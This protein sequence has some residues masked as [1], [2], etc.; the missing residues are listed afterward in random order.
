MTNPVASASARPRPSPS[1]E[2]PPGHQ[3]SWDSVTDPVMPPPSTV[4]HGLRP[5]T[6]SEDHELISYKSDTRARPAWKTIGFRLKRGPDSCKARCL[7]LRQSRPELNS[8][9]QK[10][11][12]SIGRVAIAGI[13]NLLH[14]CSHLFQGV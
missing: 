6:G 7:W 5:W 11:K 8:R 1:P 9:T 10:A 13:K 12:L 14:F 4:N 2:R 3:R